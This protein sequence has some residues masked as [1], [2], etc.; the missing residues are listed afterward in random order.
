MIGNKLQ[1]SRRVIA[2][3]TSNSVQCTKYDKLF[4]VYVEIMTY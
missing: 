2:D 4:V 1:H 3:H